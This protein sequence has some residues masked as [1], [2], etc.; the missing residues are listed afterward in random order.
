MLA[1]VQWVKNLLKKQHQN[2]IERYIISK[3]PKNAGDV[4]YWMQQY[5]YYEHRNYLSL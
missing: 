5:Y 1:I 4:E 2:D 3:N